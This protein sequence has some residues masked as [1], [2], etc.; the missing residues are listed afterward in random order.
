MKDKTATKQKMKLNSRNRQILAHKAH[1]HSAGLFLFSRLVVTWE[2]VAS[3][4]LIEAYW[5]VFGYIALRVSVAEEEE[6]S[7]PM[8]PLKKAW[9][10][11]T[12][13]LCGMNGQRIRLLTKMLVIWAHPGTVQFHSDSSSVKVTLSKVPKSFPV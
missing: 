7:T 12:L 4:G 10:H 5:S 6:S 13:H 9:F 3:F 11:Q 1:D 8:L 2:E